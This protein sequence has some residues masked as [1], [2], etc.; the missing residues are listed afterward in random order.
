MIRKKRTLPA[1]L[2]TN[3]V[4]E[5]GL[6]CFTLYV[7][8]S[9]PSHSMAKFN[10]GKRRGMVLRG[11]TLKQSAERP[12]IA[13]PPQTTRRAGIVPWRSG[14]YGHL[15]VLSSFRNIN[16]SCPRGIQVLNTLHERCLC[17][18]L[19]EKPGDRNRRLHVQ[20]QLAHR[21]LVTRCYRRD[22]LVGLH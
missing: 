10:D 2:A 9:F 18:R 14:W 4:I 8:S 15:S 12:H 21:S 17:T 13:T 16:A 19:V 11:Y 3:A 20:L 5:R 22:K 6:S 1:S 7:S